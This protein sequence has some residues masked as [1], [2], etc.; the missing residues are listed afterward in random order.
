LVLTALHDMFR[1]GG[2]DKRYL[3]LVKGRWRDPNCSMCGCPCTNT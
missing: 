1:D 2:I 3:A